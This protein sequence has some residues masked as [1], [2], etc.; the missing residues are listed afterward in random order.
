VG[1]W[2]IHK[3]CWS[4][5]L[6]GSRH[7]RED[8]KIVLREISMSVFWVVTPCGLVG[9]CQRFEKTHCLH[10]QGLSFLRNSVSPHGI[11]NQNK[12]DI[13]S[14][15]TT[16]NLTYRNMLWR[17]VLDLIG[18]GRNKMA[19][20]CKHGNEFSASVNS[21]NFLTRWATI[22]FQ[23]DTNVEVQGKYED[24][25]LM[26][27]AARTSET[28]VNFYQTTRR[29]NPEDSHLLTHCRENLKSYIDYLGLA[30]K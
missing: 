22:S 16:S 20:F 4:G 1:K 18:W 12:I 8:A 19:G 21:G 26:M 5:N 7:R 13:F 25:A 28:L 15:M 27:E 11:T 6:K 10:L 3:T 9:R 24:G 30:T 2:E 29:Y 17:Y 23:F 14:A